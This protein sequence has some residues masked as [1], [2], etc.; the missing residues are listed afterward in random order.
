MLPLNFSCGTTW[1]LWGGI[2]M[3]YCWQ[4]LVEFQ[5]LSLLLSAGIEVTLIFC[6]WHADN[7]IRNPNC[8]F[9]TI[10]DSRNCVVYHVV[11]EDYLLSNMT[12]HSHPIDWHEITQQR[13]SKLWF[14]DLGAA[15]RAVTGC[16]GRQCCKLLFCQLHDCEV[17]ECWVHGDR[18]FWW[19]GAAC[20]RISKRYTTHNIT[21]P[22]PCS[23]W[24]TVIL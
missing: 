2:Q 5:L 6:R 17:S 11:T 7:H 19:S 3:L 4:I 21:Q 12:K 8:H 13:I 20:S 15:E 18:R 23:Y 22:R 16:E 9:N 10:Q 1:C 24:Q 14:T